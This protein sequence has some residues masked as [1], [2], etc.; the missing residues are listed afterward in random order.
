MLESRA[1]NPALFFVEKLTEKK[2]AGTE[3]RPKKEAAF[4]SMTARMSLFETMMYFTL[5]TST[6]VPLYLA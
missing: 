2:R 3:T 5:S 6:S 4:Y 1:I